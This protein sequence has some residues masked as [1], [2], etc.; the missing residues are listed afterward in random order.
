MYI[1]RRL[2]WSTLTFWQYNVPSM[3]QYHVL[4]DNSCNIFIDSDALT[5]RVNETSFGKLNAAKNLNIGI[6]LWCDKRAKILHLEN[7]GLSKI[8]WTCPGLEKTTGEFKKANLVRPGQKAVVF[9]LN[10][11]KSVAKSRYPLVETNLINIS[12]GKFWGIGSRRSS[13]EMCPCWLSV[14][15]NL[16]YFE[17]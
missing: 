3:Q 2:R 13:V 4:H 14:S 5:I 7:Y 9:N 16:E 15:V 12:L 6:R 17:I 1:S 11:V 10:L 8:Y